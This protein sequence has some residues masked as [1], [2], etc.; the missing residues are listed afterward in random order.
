M[1]NKFTESAETVLNRALEIAEAFGHT[2][3][4]SDHMLLAIAEDKNSRAAEI[5][6]RYGVDQEGIRSA[7]MEISECGEKTNLTTTDATPKFRI[8]LKNAYETSVRNGG[9]QI[10]TEDILFAICLQEES[11]AI[12]ILDKLGLDLAEIKNQLSK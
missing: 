5:L 6:S 12:K 9:T 10:S 7:I 11:A 4:G 8:V 1:S 3:I 2:Y